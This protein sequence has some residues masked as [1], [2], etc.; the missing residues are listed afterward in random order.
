MR[1]LT[2]VVVALFLLAG[3]AAAASIDGK[4]VSERKMERNGET[5]TIKQTFDLKSEGNKLTGNVTMQF[6]DREPRTAEVKDGKIDGD[7]FSFSTTMSGP[8]GDMKTVYSGTVSGDTL[9]G[10]AERDG[11]QARPFEAKKQ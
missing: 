7:K 8:N 11:G 2:A 5:F 3:L 1:T 4:W 6:G 10:T 9:K